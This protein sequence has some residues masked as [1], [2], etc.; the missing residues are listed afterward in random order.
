LTETEP[1]G[2]LLLHCPEPWSEK[3]PGLH[4]V[5]SLEPGAANVSAGHALQVVAADADL[6]GAGAGN[7]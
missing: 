4:G 6:S 7:R 3:V 2:Q 5:Q 1:E